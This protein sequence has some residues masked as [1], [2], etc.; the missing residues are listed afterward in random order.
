MITLVVGNKEY[1]KES[2]VE[3][4]LKA[5]DYA[6]KMQTEQNPR[7]MLEWAV[8]FFKEEGLTL[9]ELLKLPSKEFPALLDNI[10]KDFSELMGQD[11]Q[12]TNEEDTK[13]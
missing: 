2:T 11:D 10:T 13:K 7:V 1:S 6:I 3:D 4:T 8:S 12:A 5:F 9:Q